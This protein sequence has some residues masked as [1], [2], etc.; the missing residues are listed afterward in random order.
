MRAISGGKD[1]GAH[2]SSSSSRRAEADAVLNGTFTS[3]R[4]SAA[5]AHAEDV[6]EHASAKPLPSQGV[7]AW[8]ELNDAAI[9]ARQHSQRA[10]DA[11]S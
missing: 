3:P 11:D 5:D 10:T 7:E 4:T 9:A 6:A 8:T 1:G 2:T